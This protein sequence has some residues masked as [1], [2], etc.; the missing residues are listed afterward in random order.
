MNNFISLYGEVLDYPQQA[1][2][3][4]KGTEYY[5]FNL[6]VQRESGIIDILPI[7]VEEDTAA[8]NAL[9]DIDEKGEVVGAQLLITGEIRTRNIK[10]KLDISV[11]AFSIQEDDDYKL[12]YED[13]KYAPG[14]ESFSFKHEGESYTVYFDNKGFHLERDDRQ[15]TDYLRDYDLM[16]LLEAMLE[17]GYFGVVETLKNTIKKTSKK[18]S[19]SDTT[20]VQQ[21][22]EKQGLAGA[23]NEPEAGADESQ[24]A[25]DD[26]AVDIPEATAILTADLFNLREYISEDDFYNLQEIVINCEL[27]ARKGGENEN[28][29][30]YSDRRKGEVMTEVPKEWKG[31]P[32]EWS[33][34]VEAFGRIAKAIQEA[35]RQ[36]VNS[37]SELY[38]RMAAAMGNEQVKKRLRQQSI[39]DRKKQLER[40]RKRQQLAAAIR[41]SLITS[42]DCMDFVPEE[43]I[44]NM[45]KRIDL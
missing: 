27:A 4:K 16:E 21:N 37:F 18:V 14:K 26:E 34:V 31:T 20:K 6:A 32:E 30:S 5:K 12:C 2:I 8:Y 28:N 22:Q 23:M 35:G 10:D 40:S 24:A 38:K 3:D 44:K 13:G 9:A 11:R 41:T 42:G 33:A 7:V 29:R 1:S 19:E 39:R 43:S 15:Y 17:A 36:I 45:Q 25:A